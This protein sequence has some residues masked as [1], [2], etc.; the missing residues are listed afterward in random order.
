MSEAAARAG[1]PDISVVWR[2]TVA[3]VHFGFHPP[4]ARVDRRPVFPEFNIKNG[5]GCAKRDRGGCLDGA[6]SHRTDRFSREN[7]LTGCHADSIQSSE[8]D[9]VAIAPIDN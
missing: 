5:F 6:I 7:E 4:W 3:A 2:T 9:I 8:D 1:P